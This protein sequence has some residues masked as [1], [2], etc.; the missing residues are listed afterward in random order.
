M[1]AEIDQPKDRWQFSTRGLLVLTAIVSFVLAFAVRLPTVFTVIL[2]IAA[3]VLL[4]IAV[5]HTANFATSDRRPRIAL[6]SW[7]MFATF[8]ALYSSAILSAGLQNE[9]GVSGGAIFGLSIMCLCC[10]ICLLRAWQSFRLLG[11][12]PE[13]DEDGELV[14]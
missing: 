6:L 14:E 2:L 12:G 4:L 13:S 3:P 5:F 1:T 7:L 9:R 11:R 10:V 8:F